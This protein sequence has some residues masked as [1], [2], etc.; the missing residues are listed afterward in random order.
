M[1]YLYFFILILIMNI[2]GYAVMYIDKK[3]AQKGT[4]RISEKYIF[5]LALFFGAI[6]IY[7][8]MYKF[9]HKTKHTLFTV[10]IPI[11]IIINGITIY[12][13]LSHNILSYLINY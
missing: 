9:R 13:I 1:L 7:L 8:G 2:I 10:G 12:Y 5:I 6:G 3:K 11:C 4:Y